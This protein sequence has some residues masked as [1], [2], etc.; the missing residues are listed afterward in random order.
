[1][2]APLAGARPVFVSPARE[3]AAH[4]LSQGMTPAAV[5]AAMVADGFADTA[6]LRTTISQVRAVLGLRPFAPFGGRPPAFVRAYYNARAARHGCTTDQLQARVLAIVARD[7]LL[8]AVLDSEG[9]D[10]GR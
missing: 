3:L 10:H 1:M 2:T 8:S 5:R 7:D 6:S 9:D 4:L